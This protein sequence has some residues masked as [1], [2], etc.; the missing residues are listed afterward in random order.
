M[1]K[2]NDDRDGIVYYDDDNNKLFLNDLLFPRYG[3]SFQLNFEF[4]LSQLKGI[5]IY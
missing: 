5:L 1:N 4:H 3:D 2:Y